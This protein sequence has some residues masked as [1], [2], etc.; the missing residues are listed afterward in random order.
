MGPKTALLIGT[1]VLL[2]GVLAI[3]YDFR[4]V[5]PAFGH[6]EDYGF[7]SYVSLLGFLLLFVGFAI[8]YCFVFRNWEI[9]HGNGYL[10]FRTTKT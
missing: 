5:I 10:N 7:T 2:A 3:A 8:L 9:E 1:L 4:L 6:S